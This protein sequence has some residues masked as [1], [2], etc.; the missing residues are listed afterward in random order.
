M[1]GVSWHP[2]C[3]VSLDGLRLLHLSFHG[4]DGTAHNGELVVARRW[5][6]R[7]VGVFRTLFDAG[8]PIERMVLVDDFGASDDASTLANN[9]SA[10]NCR[11]VTGG[12]GWARH[13]YG[14]AIDLDPR[15]NPYVYPDGHLLDSAAEPYRDRSGRAPGVIHERD[16]V[17][18]AF[19]SIGW[20]WGGHFTDTPDPQHF[21]VQP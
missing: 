14:T 17:Y 1:T 12:G 16:A 8:F 7:V 2:G 20:R 6:E 4:F 19:T 9:T 10:F 13:A 3:P 15:Q 11:P 5:A 21:D 18:R